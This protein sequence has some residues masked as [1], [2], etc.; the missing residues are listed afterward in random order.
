MET[1]H[2]PELDSS[3]NCDALTEDF[4]MIKLGELNK[5]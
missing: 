2:S 4:V 3:W 5:L 1:P